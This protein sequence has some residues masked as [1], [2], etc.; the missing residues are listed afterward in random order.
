[1]LVLSIKDKKV[2]LVF[3]TRT[4]VIASQLLNGSNFEDLYFKA[5]SKLDIEAL[6]KVIFAF[7]ED[8]N[9]ERS[10]KSVEEVYDF[11]DEYKSDTKKS[12]M[13]IFIEIAKVI[14]DEGFFMK[15]LTKK[16]LEDKISNPLLNI[17]MEKLTERSLEKAMSNLAEQEISSKV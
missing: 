15:K 5:M 11:L 14:N 12:Y 8:E 1:M 2:N 16:E 10:F 3:R 4:I 9:G 6:S 7:A 13:D 17:D